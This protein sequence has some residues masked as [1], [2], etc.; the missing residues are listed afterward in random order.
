M[1]GATWIDCVYGSLKYLKLNECH[2]RSSNFAGFFRTFI[3][4]VCFAQS[5]CKVCSC[6]EGRLWC[7]KYVTWTL[8]CP[9]I[10]IWKQVPTKIF[11]TGSHREISYY[12]S[13]SS[14]FL[15]K[16]HAWQKVYSFVCRTQIGATNCFI[17]FLHFFSHCLDISHLK[18]LNN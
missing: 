13:I 4:I 14:N 9:C 12:S 2:L 7:Y 17:N 1:V 10:T 6:S 15:N 3:S 16:M 18:I 5:F 8:F 11:Q